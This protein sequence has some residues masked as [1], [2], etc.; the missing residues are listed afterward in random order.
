MEFNGSQGRN[1]H[2]Q[3]RAII[4]R[5]VDDQTWKYIYHVGDHDELYH[6]DSDKWECENLASLNDHQAMR[7]YLRQQLKTW[8]DDNEVFFGITL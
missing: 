6:L 3:M 1:P 7:D 4:A 2:Y 8:P 5:T